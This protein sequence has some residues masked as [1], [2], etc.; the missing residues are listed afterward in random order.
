[1]AESLE[2]TKM[3]RLLVKQ[4]D[5]MLEILGQSPLVGLTG[6]QRERIAILAA[7]VE[8]AAP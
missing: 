6:G 4:L 7:L 3:L 1:M 5:L 8:E 2:A